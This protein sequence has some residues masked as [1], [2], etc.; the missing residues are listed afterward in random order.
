MWEGVDYLFIDEVSMI[1]CQLMAQ[2]SEALMIAKGNGSPFS[3]ISVIFASDFAQLPPVA[4][5]SLARRIDATSGAAGSSRRA[6]HKID[7]KI[8]WNSV[9]N[10]V[11]L[12][13]TMR[14]IGK[15]NR[16]FIDL[17]GCLR[18]GQCTQSDYDLLNTRLL[19][20]I[21]L[22]ER[23]QEW[24]DP[25]V[26]AADNASKDALNEAAVQAFAQCIE[27][28]MHWYYAID[29]KSGDVLADPHVRTAL[30]RAHSGRTKHR[31]GKMPLVLGMRVIAIAHNFD[32]QGGVVNG[33]TGILKRI[34][35]TVD[36][37]GHRHLTSR[38]VQLD[39]DTSMPQSAPMPGLAASEVPIL[40]DSVSL[41][42]THPYSKK[43]L[44]IQRSQVPIE[45][46]YATTTHC[47]QGQTFKRVIV[48]LANCR[49]YESPYVMLSRAT[50]LQGALILRPFSE[51]KT[52][53]HQPQDVRDETKRL[54]TLALQ[55]MI[56]TGTACE[57]LAA[58][59]ELEIIYTPQ[60]SKRAAGLST[61]DTDTTKRTRTTR[62][63]G[64]S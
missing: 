63:I 47:A 37:D 9:E 48:D 8:L 59:L 4:E 62:T 23:G 18:E 33:S 45:P 57:Q 42:F 60:A 61:R 12:T 20:N 24:S 31:I 50:S 13:E 43:R 64:P 41:N 36:D 53:C 35:Y 5:T 54:R 17:L 14:Q 27:R 10:V 51:K 58:Q 46:A 49:G 55:T 28:E 56:R 1:S 19:Q 6:Q 29:K 2:I 11:L 15:E 38:I 52:T 39:A 21:P 40:Q 32:V 3:G 22:S 26:I 34:R 25:P 16:P 44:V 30:Q 7:G